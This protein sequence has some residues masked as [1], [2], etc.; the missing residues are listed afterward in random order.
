MFYKR[1]TFIGLHMEDDL[2]TWAGIPTR[3]GIS[4]NLYEKK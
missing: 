2:W 1:S 3:T 4:V